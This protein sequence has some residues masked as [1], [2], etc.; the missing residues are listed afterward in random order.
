[1]NI[2][3][4][5][6]ADLAEMG[7]HSLANKTWST[8]TTAERIQYCFCKK[9]LCMKNPFLFVQFCNRL[10]GMFPQP[11]GPWTKVPIFEIEK[12]FAGLIANFKTPFESKLFENNLTTFA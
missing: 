9:Q 1:M 5:V 3:A 8:Y 6:A 2:P 12:S 11:F 7:S 4:T 10:S